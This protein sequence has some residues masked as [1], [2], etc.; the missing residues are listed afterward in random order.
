MKDAAFYL[1]CFVIALIGYL[2]RAR[3]A[4]RHKILMREIEEARLS[5]VDARIM[6]I[7]GRPI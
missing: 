4:R 6:P 7:H 2:I 1:G 5:L 3:A